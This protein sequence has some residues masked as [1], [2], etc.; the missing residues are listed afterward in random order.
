MHPN[1]N[2]QNEHILELYACMTWGNSI[3][4]LQ[5]L[6]K[7][8]ALDKL[9]VRSTTTIKRTTP[10]A[11]VEIM[12][13]LMPI[14]LMI[15]KTGISAYIRLR[16]QLA[17]PFQVTGK[18]VIPHLQYWNNLINEYN[19]ETPITDTCNTRVW[20]KRYNVNLESLKDGKKHL[21]HSE[22]TIYTDGSKKKEGTGGGFVVYNYNNIMHTYSFKME[23]HAT[24]YQAELEAI[25]RAC[26]YMDDNYDAKANLKELNIKYIKILSDSQAAIKALNKPRITSQSVL[27]TLEYMETLALEVKHLTLAWI[28]AHVGTEGNEQAD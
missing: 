22:Y 19:I 9:A 24:V 18:M 17:V 8:K 4:T 27:T 15:K 1:R 14:E 12:I 26:K 7:L 11:S 20:E 16:R 28:K 23:D 5:Q 25:Y 13:D 6:K 3:N 2:C 21:R 10:Q